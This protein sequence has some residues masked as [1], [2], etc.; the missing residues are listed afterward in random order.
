MVISRFYP[1]Y[2]VK[3]RERK[4]KQNS[5]LHG[6]AR[7]YKQAIVANMQLS[8]YCMENLIFSWGTNSRNVHKPSD[9]I[10]R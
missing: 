7:N 9:I 2:L 3:F 4:E 1:G 5:I 6:S 10:N 8:F